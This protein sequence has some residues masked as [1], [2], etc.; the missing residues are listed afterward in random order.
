MVPS[1][2]CRMLCHLQ[3]ASIRAQS[4]SSAITGWGRRSALDP[5]ARCCHAA[6]LAYV[7]AQC[8]QAFFSLHPK[9]KLAF[10]NCSRGTFP[11]CL[12]VKVAEHVLTKHKVAIKILNR[13]KIRQMDMEEKGQPKSPGSGVVQG[14]QG[15]GPRAPA[16]VVWPPRVAF[17][18]PARC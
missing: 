7:Y 9:Q 2:L 18:V 6:F 8:C 1:G 14:V 15:A 5:L 13:R 12:Q 17:V 11:D 4:S 3:R 16:S 10:C